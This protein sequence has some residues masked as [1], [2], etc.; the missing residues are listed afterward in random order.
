MGRSVFPGSFFS[1]KKPAWFRLTSAILLLAY[2]SDL[3]GMDW[4]RTREAYAQSVVMAPR[5]G[6][7]V[8]ASQAGSLPLLKAI[9]IDPADPLKIDFLVDAGDHLKADEKASTRLVQYFLTFLT[10]PE[11]D[12]WVNL[13]PLE[14]ERIINRAL[15]RTA[16]GEDMLKEDYLLKQLAAS[17]TFP[18]QDP[19]KAFW[20]KIRSRIQKQYGDIDLPLD[21]FS[22]VWVVPEKALVYEEKG[23]AFIA[24]SRLKVMFDE[25]Y[26]TQTKKTNGNHSKMNGAPGLDSMY[27]AIAREIIIPELEREVNQGQYFAPLRQMFNALILAIWFKRKLKDNIVNLIYTD[28]KKTSGIQI[29]D[30][31]ISQK[32][33]A[34]YMSALRKG[35]YDVIREEADPDQQGTT[36]RRYFSGGL[37]FE[38]T[39]SKIDFASLPDSASERKHVM[40]G[41]GKNIFRL[42]TSLIPKGMSKKSLLT[43]LLAA[44]ML[45]SPGSGPINQTAAHGGNKAPSPRIEVVAGVD[46]VSK[47]IIGHGDMIPESDKK[48][49]SFM[50]DFLTIEDVKNIQGKPN[51]LTGK[52]YILDTG[53]IASHWDK[54]FT[55]SSMNWSQETMV[56]ALQAKL[57]LP[58]D[59]Q[60]G[61][62][63]RGA[64]ERVMSL[65]TM[66]L[67][68]GVKGAVQAPGPLSVVKDTLTAVIRAVNP[69][70]ASDKDVLRDNIKTFSSSVV[71]AGSGPNP[72]DDQDFKYGM[73]QIVR[74]LIQDPN[75]Q[76]RTAMLNY[77]LQN[78]QT[79]PQFT[80]VVQTIIL[81]SPYMHVVQA[82]L[83]HMVSKNGGDLRFFIQLID[84][85]LHEHKASTLVD[86]ELQGLADILGKGQSPLNQLLAMDQPRPSSPVISRDVTRRVLLTF[87][88]WSDDSI[89]RGH[90][91]RSE[92][93]NIDQLTHIHRALNAARGAMAERLKLDVYNEILR[94]E[95]LRVIESMPANEKPSVFSTQEDIYN[96]YL[97]TKGLKA[98]H[99]PLVRT[100]Y[101]DLRGNMPRWLLA[102]AVGAAE[103]RL[104]LPVA[105]HMGMPVLYDVPPRGLAEAS[106]PEYLFALDPVAQAAYLV[107]STNIDELARIFHVV[108]PLRSKALDRLMATPRGR[109]LA[110][111]VYA[112]ADDEDLLA[113]V[114]AKADWEDLLRK[115][116]QDIN[117]PVSL[118]V[119]H[120]AMAKMYNRPWGKEWML[121]IRLKALT[122]AE[123]EHADDP[124][125]RRKVSAEKESRAIQQALDL[126][127]EMLANPPS[128]FI[129]KR[130]YISDELSFIAAALVNKITAGD[131]EEVMAYVNALK[132]SGDTN[133]QAIGEDIEHWKN[134][135]LA[136]GQSPSSIPFINKLILW[137]SGLFLSALAYLR[138]RKKTAL[139]KA[140]VSKLILKLR[141]TFLV[142]SIDVQGV[143]QGNTPGFK[144]A[145]LAAMPWGSSSTK[146]NQ[147]V[148]VIPRRGLFNGTSNYFQ[149]WQSM[150]HG[151][152]KGNAPPD[153]QGI[154]NGLNDILNNAFYILRATPYTPE[155]IDK[156]DE[157]ILLNDR[158]R[159]TF[160]YFNLLVIDTLDTLSDLL[161]GTNIDQRQRALLS[162]DVGVLVE[163]NKYFMEYLVIL[164]CRG[165]IDK[166]MGYKF[167][168]H[169][170]TERSGLYPSI[171]WFL[172]Y[173]YLLKASKKKLLI[174]LPGLLSKGNAL[175]PGLYGSADA[176]YF[177]AVVE[178]SETALTQMIQRAD[179]LTSPLSKGIG[180]THKMRSFVSRLRLM[181]VPLILGFVLSMTFLGL[182]SVQ[183]PL[184]AVWGV[185]VGF[186]IYW[187]PHTNTMQMPWR[188]AMEAVTE[189]LDAQLRMSLGATDIDEQALVRLA[190]DEGADELKKE[191]AA[192]QSSLDMIVIIP[193]EPS[194]AGSLKEYVRQRRGTIIRKDVPV[195]VLAPQRKGSANIYFEALQLVQN[196]LRDQEFLEQNPGL[197][198]RSVQDVRILFVFHG[199][200][201]IQDD[202][203]LDWTIVNGYRS[204]G[205]M[206]AKEGTTLPD[207]QR[208]T[209]GG[210]IIRYS[211]D[212]SFRPLAQ[213]NFDDVALWGDWVN[214]V[215]LETLGL[216]ITNLTSENKIE[217]HEVLEKLNI[218]ALQKDGDGDPTY[219]NKVLKYLEDHYKL[220]QHSLK[221]FPALT[222]GMV[223]SPRTVRVLESV[224]VQLEADPGLWKQLKYL[225]L[226]T[227]ILNNLLKSSDGMKDYV[228][229]RINLPD[230][231]DQYAMADHDDARLLF[232]RF[233]TIFARAKEDVPAGLHFSPI[234]AYPGAAEVWHIRTSDDVSRIKALLALKPWA[235]SSATPDLAPK[236]KAD[237]AIDGG[238]D[239]TMTQEHIEYK[240]RMPSTLPGL[241]AADP[242]RS[243]Q[244]LQLFRGFDFSITASETL[245]DPRVF[246]GF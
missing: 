62:Q 22:K 177:K 8:P 226:T 209:H 32:V 132:L 203:I 19:G 142:D 205:A 65:K 121:N 119:I 127:K 89:A 36:P 110:L 198:G 223:F 155:L 6:V 122:P 59:G 228:D 194:Y 208:M 218:S 64:L 2:T 158:Y 136:E 60:F 88:A 180:Y 18:D 231:E 37:T 140:S 176:G 217:I 68:T 46:I 42:T 94:R 138:L 190:L 108:T 55:Y 67:K 186:L 93:W 238:L 134:K 82:L 125:G 242:S 79:D 227:D 117:D 39:S 222:E 182:G 187:V 225:H 200:N 11:K 40:R 70:K 230:I 102:K 69:G 216:F 221:Q 130:P 73:D 112:H 48:Y 120:Q 137:G 26:M 20:A 63:T 29:K 115:D 204:A 236:N 85:S 229:K 84:K 161:E 86:M 7:L 81:N 77:L 197:K 91:L 213:Q 241:P 76:A 166:V 103:Q 78:D 201:K 245:T 173:T 80:P 145:F 163:M 83:L 164:E 211:R 56:I 10:I 219:R 17:M 153:G 28:K 202:S 58:Q 61:P 232:K 1:L 21:T 151:W 246:L 5:P 30:R 184:M 133:K 244:F 13:S 99:D 146:K 47:K 118:K 150:V 157:G 87:L 220:P 25:D 156:G 31:K 144:D 224:L 148:V 98:L 175:M 113:L 51:P 239:F 123:L 243:L 57:G 131:P 170:W 188:A 54:I 168:D 233:Y 92:Y 234:M 193:E 129:G 74:T 15:G 66:T 16:V 100:A 185:L 71:A 210:H 72:P 160:T 50:K 135:F 101:V 199:D 52:L 154:I 96:Y 159:A 178:R 105:S 3:I 41:F 165:V 107:Q 237:S 141:R 192:Q 53:F 189:K 106:V 179:N 14:P 109:I 24:E 4:I 152:R 95:A 34:R 171:R 172:L 143:I 75:V 214:Q 207:G 45:V 181:S 97:A 128:L 195:E 104:A 43:L 139:G 49:F 235:L 35:V 23:I 38:R 196:R 240:E 116:I 124:R 212:V 162:R 9:A 206:R 90:L 215:D 167:P 44:G 149:G 183:I 191:L 12:L 111:Q 126:M 174:G 114:E 169:H 27:L 147:A 33:Y